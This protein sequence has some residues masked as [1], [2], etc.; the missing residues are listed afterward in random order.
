MIF[1]D[2]VPISLFT[3]FELIAI[4]SSIVWVAFSVH[5]LKTQSRKLYGRMI[6][7]SPGESPMLYTLK[8]IFLT[9]LY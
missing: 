8:G 4:S 2:G 7:N 1:V 3:G 6:I 5:A 9:L